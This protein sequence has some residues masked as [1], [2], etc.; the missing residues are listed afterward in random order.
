MPAITT[1]SDQELAMLVSRDDS[2]AYDALFRRHWK[3]IYSVAR[4]LLKSDHLAE[5][6]VQ[7]VFLKVWSARAEL[8]A[9]R[10][11]ENWLFIIARNHIYNTLRRKM[12]EKSFL[13][14]LS[15]SFGIRQTGP[16]EMLQVKERA[17]LL[18][19]MIRQLPPQQQVVLRMAHQADM[20]YEHIGEMMGISRNTVRNHL[21]RAVQTLRFQMRKAP[22]DLS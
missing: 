12:R 9:I 5:E 3:R 22:E 17:R 15:E 20:S 10:S 4:D 14:M 11:F 13:S 6:A 18:D 19:D 7:E 8:V 21:A 16:E 1:V 2:R